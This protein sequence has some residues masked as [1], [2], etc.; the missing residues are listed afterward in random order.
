MFFCFIYH[1]LLAHG[2]QYCIHFFVHYSEC[3]YAISREHKLHHAMP[4]K[5]TWYG[6]PTV[7]KDIVGIYSIAFT[8]YVLHIFYFYKNPFLHLAMFTVLAISFS[9]FHGLCHYLSKE[10]QQKIPY[11]N[12]L[13]Y[14]HYKHHVVRSK[15]FGFGDLT[16]DFLFGTLDLDPL[17]FTDEKTKTFDSKYFIRPIS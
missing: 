3:P 9:T 6:N 10:F 5:I 11:L 12:V 8:L 16:Y 13:F 14:H 17:E 2:V 1:Y 7:E 4:H 15:N